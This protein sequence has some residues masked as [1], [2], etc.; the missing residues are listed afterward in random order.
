M[1]QGSGQVPLHP[2]RGWMPQPSHAV[3]RATRQPWSPSGMAPASP[4]SESKSPEA[5]CDEDAAGRGTAPALTASPKP[6]QGQLMAVIQMLMEQMSRLTQNVDGLKTQMQHH[7]NEQSLPS[8]HFALEMTIPVQSSG[9]GVRWRAFLDTTDTAVLT[10][11]HAPTLVEGDRLDYVVLINMPTCTAETFLVRSLLSN[12]FALE[13]TFPAQSAP[14][15]PN[16]AG[17]LP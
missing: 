7:R 16:M 14:A 2:H 6:D 3:K 10:G 1:L 13:T 8:N 11:K 17:T 5:D 12:H 15:V 9:N 4:A